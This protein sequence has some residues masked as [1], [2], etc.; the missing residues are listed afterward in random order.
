MDRAHLT[1]NDATFSLQSTILCKLVYPIPVTMF[2][3][4]QGHGIMLCRHPKGG[5]H[6]LHAPCGGVWAMLVCQPQYPQLL[7]KTTGGATLDV[8]IIW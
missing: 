4:Q 1:H 5:M 2:T 8:A 3:E 6:L 7:Y